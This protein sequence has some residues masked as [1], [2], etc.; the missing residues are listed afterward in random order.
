[1]ICGV[2]YRWANAFQHRTYAYSE[3]IYDG[4][5]DDGGDDEILEAT[6]IE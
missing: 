1:M 6:I 4:S 5:G 3:F 2:L